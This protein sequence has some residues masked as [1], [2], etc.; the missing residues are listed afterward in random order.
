MQV[1]QAQLP[2]EAKLAQPPP[3]PSQFH[4]CKSRLNPPPAVGTQIYPSW[5]LKSKA[6][7]LLIERALSVLF[8][9][10]VAMRA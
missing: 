1:V 9:P 10:L 4:L 2:A 6:K 5:S 3:T 8:Y 7:L